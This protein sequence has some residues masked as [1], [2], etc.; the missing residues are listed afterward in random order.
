MTVPA[1]LRPAIVFSVLPMAF[2]AI[3]AADMILTETLLARTDIN[4][5]EL[6]PLINTTD[7]SQNY[8]PQMVACVL[9]GISAFWALRQEALKYLLSGKLI[10]ITFKTNPNDRKIGI[11]YGVLLFCLTMLLARSVVVLHLTTISL[12]EINLLP[13]PDW[14]DNL[15]VIE[16]FSGPVKMFVKVAFINVV[17]LVP[18]VPI[19][20]MTA[21]VAT[22]KAASVLT[23][24][25]ADP[26]GL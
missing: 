10:K 7:F 23:T 17:F 20:M 19:T 6:N 24:G 13:T 4:V 2:I 1:F 25:N 18:V 26:N 15:P 22:T 12:F 16:S 11:S 8:F 9:F 5:R 14:T 21:A 3:S